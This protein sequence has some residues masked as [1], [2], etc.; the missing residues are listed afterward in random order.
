MNVASTLS[1]DAIACGT[2]VV[3]F[4]FDAELM[5]PESSVRRLCSDYV[6]HLMDSRGTW[7]AENE[8]EFLEMLKAVLERGE[9]DKQHS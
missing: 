1:L 8:E 3:N 2:E 7:F 4:N 6:K 9:K 5:P